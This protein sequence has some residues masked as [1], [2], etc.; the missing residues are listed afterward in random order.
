MKHY[1]E[2]L[3]RLTPERLFRL[4]VACLGVVFLLCLPSILQAQTPDSIPQ[5]PAVEPELPDTTP[6]Y[7]VQAYAPEVLGLDV[8]TMA[9]MPFRQYDPARLQLIDYGTLGNVGAAARPLLSEAPSRRGFDVGVR[10]FDI[11]RLQPEDLRFYRRQRTFSDVYFSQGGNQDENAVK[12]RFSRTFSDGANISFDYR[13]I[14]NLGVFKHQ[15]IRHNTLLGGL[16]LPVG[17]RYEG[18]LIFSKS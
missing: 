13:T 1:T 5:P 4:P 7:F 10:A 18:F 6:L 15:A 16:W 12:A 11:Y 8:D 3:R 2:A 17:K 9:G 14:T